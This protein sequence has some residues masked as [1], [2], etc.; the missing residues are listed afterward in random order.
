MADD[1]NSE[2]RPYNDAISNL[3]DT[4]KWIVSSSAALAALIVGGNSLS[5]I[6]ALGFGGRLWLAIGSSLLS[7][8]LIGALLWQAV[9][10]LSSTRG[11]A[12]SELVA[13]SRYKKHRCYLDKNFVP[14]LPS[15][16]PDLRTLQAEYDRLRR[17]PT[18]PG[19]P[20]Y[21]RYVFLI[22][23]VTKWLD[24]TFRF[25]RLLWS[26]VGIL[27]IVLVCTY[28]FIWAANP[29]KDI[30]KDLDIP[31][32]MEMHVSDADLGTFDAAGLPQKCVRP[33][34]GVILTRE[35]PANLSDGV[36]VPSPGCPSHRIVVN[37][38]SNAVV[39]VQ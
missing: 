38:R 13:N 12:L 2:S 20:V 21:Q 15:V 27:P 23:T 9:E 29:P 1:E 25:K 24:T 5:G 10:V 4:T 14:Y 6:G 34:L 31:V 37:A 19:F 32:T 36:T 11:V 30:G 3:R 22:L 33:V 17:Q 26:F 7:I 8:L 28:L 39:R 35:E 16:T 18:E